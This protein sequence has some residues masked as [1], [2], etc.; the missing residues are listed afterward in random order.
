MCSDDMR[1]INKQHCTA[2]PAAGNTAIITG[3]AKLL[4]LFSVCQRLQT[5]IIIIKSVKSTMFHYLM[6][7]CMSS[8]LG[9]I[10]IYI[11]GTPQTTV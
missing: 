9:H 5:Q 11:Y 1:I 10:Y 6:S 8:T 3:K 7:S 2:L 4:C